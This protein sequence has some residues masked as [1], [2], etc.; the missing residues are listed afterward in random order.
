M[1]N[2]YKQYYKHFFQLTTLEETIINECYEGY[3]RLTYHIKKG[4]L[5]S[6]NSM[7]GASLFYLAD[8]A[9]IISC[10][11]YNVICVT[12]SSNINFFKSSSEGEL[13]II[14][15]ES[16][17]GKKNYVANIEFILDGKETIAQG[18]FNLFILEDLNL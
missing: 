8:I 11:T 7:H 18:T 12:Q 13:T 2:N 5:N 10:E 15:K 3:C 9:A 6:L 1:T 4:A 17:K 14:A 16:Y